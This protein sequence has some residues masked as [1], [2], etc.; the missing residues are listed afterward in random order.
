MKFLKQFGI[1]FGLCWLG[2]MVE[3][4]VPVPA[5]VLAL[6]FLLLLLL[7]RAVRVEQL[8]ETSDFLLNNLP[9]FFVPISVGILQYVDVI[10][11]HGVAFLT[12]CV[13]SLVTT[14]AATVWTV[15]WTKHWMERGKKA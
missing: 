5:S 7:L 2:Q 1:L 12:V 8:E 10:F 4:V 9:F 6:L 11:S 13:V 15:R 3:R 14:F